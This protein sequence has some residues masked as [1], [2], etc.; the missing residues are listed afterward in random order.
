MRL[1][2]DVVFRDL[3]GE[4]VILD[5]A[6]GRY[7]GLNA[8]GTRIWTLLD[9]GMPIERIVQTLAEEY[10]ADAAQIDRDVKA[11]IENLSSRGLIVRS[12][13]L[14]RGPA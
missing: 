2:P 5:L 3:E 14:P 7:F 11:L 4:A 9:A 13:E 10:D 12:D 8:V 1:S 6:S